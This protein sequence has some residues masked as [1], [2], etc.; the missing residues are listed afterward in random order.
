[1]TEHQA[2]ALGHITLAVMGPL[3]VVAEVGAVEHP[4]DDLAQGEDADNSAV[5][6][7]ADQEALHV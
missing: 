2:H 6:E 7:P 1:M 3:G 4:E 5:G